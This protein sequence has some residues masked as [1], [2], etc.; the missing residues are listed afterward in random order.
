MFVRGI[1]AY[2][3]AN[4][5]CRGK[6]L[7]HSYQVA[8]LFFTDTMKRKMLVDYDDHTAATVALEKGAAQNSNLTADI[9]M[10]MAQNGAAIQ[11]NSSSKGVGAGTKAASNSDIGS[12]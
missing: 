4:C 3:I 10:G 11:N 7:F 1:P 5:K 9:E 12:D 2:D 8:T 6:V